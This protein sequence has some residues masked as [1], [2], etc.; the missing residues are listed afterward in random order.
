MARRTVG[1][2]G[3]AGMPLPT[4]P[5]GFKLDVPS[6][7]SRMPEP[8]PCFALDSPP[9]PPPGFPLDTAPEPPPGFTLD[10]LNDGPESDAPRRTL[11][12]VFT[13][14]ARKF[15]GA[16]LRMAGGIADIATPDP[17]APGE[18]RLGNLL[19]C[20]GGAVLQKLDWLSDNMYACF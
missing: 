19:A 1:A 4:P 15:S 11:S 10:S 20:S 8:P 9:S 16:L 2:V 7:A 17:I 5:P 18:S 13:D 3:V 14:P 12:E 6:A